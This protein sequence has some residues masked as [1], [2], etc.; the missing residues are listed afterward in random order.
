MV[1]RVLQKN[2]V[3]EHIGLGLRLVVYSVLPLFR[4]NAHTFMYAE[5]V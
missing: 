2:I 5:K 1:S 3:G 4:E